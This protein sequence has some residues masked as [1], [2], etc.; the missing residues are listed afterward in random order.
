MG[1]TSVLKK[2]KSLFGAQD[3][4]VGSP[5]KCLLMFSVPLLIGNLA[6][7]LYSTVDSIVVGK[8]VGDLA[9]SAIGITSPIITLFMV[10]FMAI[11]SG[12][13]V[14]VSQYFG[15]KEYKPLAKT[16]GN[17]FTLIA[18]ASVFL[19]FVGIGITGWVLKLIDTPAEVYDMA[20]AYLI[21]LFIGSAGDGFY[22]IFSG[23]LRGLG[24][25]VYPL[26]VLLL[27]TVLNIALDIWFVVGF[28]MGV[29]G[30]A[31]ATTIC[32][33]VSAIACVVK[34][35][36]IRGEF[37]IHLS[38]CKL[39]KPIVFTICRLGIPNGISQGVLFL[40]SIIIQTFINRM[41]YLVT[42][43]ITAVLR[44]DAFAVI[45]S[46]TFG[47]CSSTFTGQNVGAGKYDR[48]KKGSIQVFFMSLI[49]TS[50]MVILMLVFGKWMMSL[51]TSTN[52]VIDMG[53][54][55]IKV[56]LPA[57]FLMAVGQSFGGVIRGAGD[58]MPPMWINLITNTVIRI[59][60]MLLLVHFTASEIYPAGNPKSSF[61]ALVITMFINAVATMIYY[62]TGK[63]KTKSIIGK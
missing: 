52:E 22:N 60:A 30:A 39:T 37:K 56:M 20:K 50:I 21:I 7:L 3:M 34:V 61:I 25:S 36:L 10:V 9:L 6:Q 54:E 55:F 63:W 49:T 26:I 40:A 17:S 8:Y 32:K 27:T 4:T 14:M 2:F 33:T 31:W 42:A 59:P 28:K 51:F 57:Y 18:L 41:G 1:V 29:A 16:I 62:S 47:M 45:P 58:T 11:G 5:I 19:T 48:V 12:V 35:L 23:I 53:Y 24:E 13:M 46:Q 44:V 15:A 43:S 38:D